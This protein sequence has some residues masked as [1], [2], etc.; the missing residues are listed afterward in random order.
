MLSIRAS[1]VNDVPLSSAPIRE[2]AEYDPR[3]AEVL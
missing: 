2:R 1:T 3:L